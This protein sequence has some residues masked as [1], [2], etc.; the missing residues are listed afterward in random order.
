[1]DGE[2]IGGS[3]V[4]RYLE[5]T[6]AVL[7]VVV[8]GIA[9]GHQRSASATLY[10]PEELQF[11]HLINQYREDHRAGPLLLSD[12]LALSA[13]HHSHDMAK[14]DFF[15]HTTASSFYY[16]VGS[17]PWDRMRAEG[18]DYNTRMGEN[19]AVGCKSAGKCFELWRNSPPHN[20]A[21]LDGRYRVMGVARIY[22]PG[23]AHGWYWATDFGGRWIP[24]P[25]R[26]AKRTSR[27]EMAP[28]SGTA[29]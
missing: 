3:N 9:A 13:E 27:S 25:T 2:A 19:I 26:R 15:A 20:A 4:L 14:Y 10:D 29:R 1:M 18:Y 12:T 8:A 21:M 23:S 22:M 6:V 28:E 16:P 24:L 5:A 17:M 11:L 7:A